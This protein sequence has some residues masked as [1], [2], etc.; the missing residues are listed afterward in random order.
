MIPL[1]KYAISAISAI[2]AVGCGAEKVLP[3]TDSVRVEYRDRVEVVHD[4]ITY[5]IPSIV[6]KIVTNDTISHLS[7]EYASSDAIVTDGMLTHLLKTNPHTIYIPRD[8]MVEV[9]DTLY[10]A[11]ETKYVDRIVE[12]THYPHTYWMLLAFF[13]VVVAMFIKRLFK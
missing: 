11:S 1:G 7:N 6:E 13:T 9:H 12:K 5:E 2:L 8:V 10:R 4:T 3:V